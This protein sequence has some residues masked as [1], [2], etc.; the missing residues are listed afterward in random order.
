MNYKVKPAIYILTLRFNLHKNTFKIRCGIAK[1]RFCLKS[2]IKTDN[3]ITYGTDEASEIVGKDES[4]NE[5]VKLSWHDNGFLNE[6]HSDTVQT[7]IIGHYN[8]INL[9]CA[10]CIGNY[11]K[12]DV[13]D[14]HVALANYVPGMNRSEVYKTKNI[15]PK[16]F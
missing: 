6:G 14:I 10:V 16:F 4:N 11:F 5:F 12:V 1:L 3:I 2:L 7:K 15:K 13:E 8:F 9:L